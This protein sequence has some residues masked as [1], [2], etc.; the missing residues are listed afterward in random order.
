L[1]IEEIPAGLAKLAVRRHQ[2]LANLRASI[3]S[4]KNQP[5]GELPISLIEPED[6]HSDG[7]IRIKD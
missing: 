7:T 1:G 2:F 6:I 5:N 4:L 3:E